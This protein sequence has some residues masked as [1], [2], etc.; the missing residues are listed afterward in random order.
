M[1]RHDPSNLIREACV[2]ALPAH[3]RDQQVLEYGGDEALKASANVKKKFGDVITIALDH[4]SQLEKD[5]VKVV[6]TVMLALKSPNFTVA[7]PSIS[8]ITGPSAAAIKTPALGFNNNVPSSVVTI[9][10]PGEVEN[11][12]RKRTTSLSNNESVVFDSMVLPQIQ[13]SRPSNVIPSP[14]GPS[15]SSL[16]QQAVMSNNNNLQPRQPSYTT[17][18]NRDVYSQISSLVVPDYT[19]FLQSFVDKGYRIDEVKYDG[20]QQFRALAHQVSK[21]Q[22][23]I[24]V[25]MWIRSTELSIRIQSCAC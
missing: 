2:A 4:L 22:L 18:F 3:R 19:Q 24:I 5:L 6:R 8:T 11:R 7:H 1:F 10:V 23:I 15:N 16:I 14:F 12:K 17:V 20:N 21:P 25:L 9:P 13:D